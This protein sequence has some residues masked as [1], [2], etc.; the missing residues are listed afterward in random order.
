LKPYAGPNPSPPQE[1]RTIH[2]DIK[3]SNLLV[4]ATGNVKIADFGVSGELSC[5]LSKCTSW[6]GTM[7]YMAPERITAAPYS[8]NSGVNRTLRGS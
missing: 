2:R 3:P 8:Y 6:V 7:H 5:T 4:D 1:R